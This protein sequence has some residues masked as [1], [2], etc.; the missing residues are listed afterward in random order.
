MRWL[1]LAAVLCCAGPAALAAPPASA[2]AASSEI[3]DLARRWVDVTGFGLED[4]VHGYD[5]KALGAMVNAAPPRND[6]ALVQAARDA[7]AAAQP[8]FREAVAKVLVSAYD[9]DTLRRL[10]AY[11]ESPAGRAARRN[12]PIVGE[13]RKALAQIAWPRYRAVFE[14]SLCRNLACATRPAPDPGRIDW[15]PPPASQAAIDAA[16]A[17]LREEGADSQA[18]LEITAD[19]LFGLVKEESAFR[20][21][22]PAVASADYE[23][24]ATRA[25][26]AAAAQ[27]GPE[28]HHQI[29]LI[30]ASL[31]TAAGLQAMTRNQKELGPRLPNMAGAIQMGR[32]LG[33]AQRALLADIKAR[34]CRKAACA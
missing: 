9:E 7:V 6:A 3:L 30:Y 33:G 18:N 29:V 5:P 14:G 26:A 8:G 2:A 19:E 13:R 27:L 11:E 21:A 4:L 16:D 34:Y 17:Y 20:A 31:F 10:V 22:N 24:A 1:A 12:E 23:A 32:I 15:K 28:Y 25:R